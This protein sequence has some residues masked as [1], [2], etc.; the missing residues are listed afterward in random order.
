MTTITETL[1]AIE[2]RADRAV[3][4][5]LRLM[6]QEILAMRSQ[7]TLE[8]RAHADALLLKLG[9][10][11]SCQRVDTAAPPAMAVHGFPELP[12]VA[13]NLQPCC[14]LVHFYGPEL[15][16]IERVDLTES[17]FAAAQLVRQQL[18]ERP[19]SVWQVAFDASDGA[20]AFVAHNDRRLA[21]ILP[22]QPRSLDVESP[23]AEACEA[24]IAGD[25]SAL[26]RLFVAPA[27]ARSR[28]QPLAA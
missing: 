14:Y 24:W 10:L 2:L 4:Q 7:L 23:V 15:G 17:L 26:R 12:L 16:D 8:D 25:I 3:V 1:C 5:E 9:H 19:H 18:S 20:L 28:P 22:C 11:E 6:T 21:S 13:P 27:Q